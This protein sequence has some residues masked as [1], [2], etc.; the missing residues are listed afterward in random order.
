MVHPR[1]ERLHALLRID[2]WQ[3]LTCSP[4][5]A[6]A[7]PQSIQPLYDRR[8][9][10]LR[11][12]RASRPL[13]RAPRLHSVE[14]PDPLMGVAREEEGTRPN[15]RISGRPPRVSITRPKLRASVASDSGQ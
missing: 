12:P 7:P 3:S 6:T 10:R 1:L 9:L 11:R 4:P 2:C 13:T 14:P 5:S 8:E 15:E